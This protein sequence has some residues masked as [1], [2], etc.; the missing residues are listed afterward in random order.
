MYNM[1]IEAMHG[2][3]GNEKPADVSAAERPEVER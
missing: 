2:N 3:A 1:H